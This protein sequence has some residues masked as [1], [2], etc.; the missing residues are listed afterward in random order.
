MAVCCTGGKG[1]H[2]DERRC[3][4]C[5]DLDLEPLRTERLAIVDDDGGAWAPKT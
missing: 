5:K 1:T 4:R 2:G 3:L